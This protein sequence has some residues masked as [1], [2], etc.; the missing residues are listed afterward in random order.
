MKYKNLVIL[1]LITFFLFFVV[2]KVSATV[3]LP[4]ISIACESKIGALFAFNDGFSLLKK[5]PAGSQQV[6][7]IGEKGD[8]GDKGDT[9]S[10]DPTILTDLNNKISDLQ[11]R[12]TVLENS[13]YTPTPTPGPV[14]TTITSDGSW[15][16]SEF[17]MLGWNEVMFDDSSWLT[18][19]SPPPLGEC[20]TSPPQSMWAQ[21]P[22]TST[23]Y[24]RKVFNVA[25]P[26]TGTIK[27]SI[28]TGG[29]VYVNGVSVISGVS[30]SPQ[31]VNVGPYLTVGNNVI[32]VSAS[33]SGSCKWVQ[34]ELSLY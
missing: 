7:L 17:N 1:P 21:S 9:G 3:Q 34:V 14:I 2:Y 23:A 15:K 13:T 19:L 32:A 33:A 30:T 29:E 27:A 18:S 28:D 31:T 25:S 10:V 6:V 12:V 20:M 22:F 16:Y 24:F 26:K 8:K 5:C 4:R 11:N